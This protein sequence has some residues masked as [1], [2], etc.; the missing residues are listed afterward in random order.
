MAD[1][2]MGRGAGTRSALTCQRRRVGV[3][4]GRHVEVGKGRAGYRERERRVRSVG[5]AG[6]NR[7]P[8]GAGGGEAHPGQLVDQG[9][10]RAPEVPEGGWITASVINADFPSPSHPQSATCPSDLSP[11]DLI[12]GHPP[13]SPSPSSF[14]RIVLTRRSATKQKGTRVGMH[15]TFAWTERAWS[16]TPKHTETRL[17]TCTAAYGEVEGQDEACVR[18]GRSCRFGVDL[19]NREQG[20]FMSKPVHDTDSS[21]ILKP[22]TDPARRPLAQGVKLTGKGCPPRLKKLLAWRKSQQRGLNSK[23]VRQQDPSFRFT[24]PKRSVFCSQWMKVVNS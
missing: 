1:G 10:L 9:V 24:P 23:P 4:A 8:R 11:M 16:W 13:S 3:A 2:L 19:A 17:T 18:V 12:T 15:R 21:T 14:P 5:A 6:P 7:H 20:G 22:V